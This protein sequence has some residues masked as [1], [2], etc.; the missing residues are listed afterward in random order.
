VSSLLN[1]LPGRL[2]PPGAPRWHGRGGLRAEREASS[3]TN[4]LSLCKPRGDQ[5]MI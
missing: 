4:S 3:L 2:A 1:I 5:H